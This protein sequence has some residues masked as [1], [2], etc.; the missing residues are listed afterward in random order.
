ML[1]CVTQFSHA[2]TL[3]DKKLMNVIE[4]NGIPLVMEL[5]LRRNE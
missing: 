3:R 2:K 1:N 5:L 4:I